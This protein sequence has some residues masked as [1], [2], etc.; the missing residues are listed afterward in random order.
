M[1]N[2]KLYAYLKQIHLLEA[3]IYTMNQAVE[4]LQS[5][6]RML[7]ERPTVQLQIP[8]EPQC[9]EAP[10]K[11]GAGKVAGHIAAAYF[12][13]GLSLIYSG[14]KASKNIK[15][16]S[17]YETDLAAWKLEH[18]AWEKAKARMIAESEACAR[19][20]FE[21]ENAEIQSYNNSISNIILE[22][23]KARRSTASALHSLYDQN[24][25]HEKYRG[26]IPIGMFCEY[27]ETGRRFYLSGKD[28][29]YDL[30]EREL[31]ARS[32]VSE[33]QTINS[34]LRRIQ[35]QM[36]EI[37]GQLSSIQ[38]NQVLTYKAVAEGNRIANEIKNE[39]I[40]LLE[41]SNE[42]LDDARRDIASIKVSSR[43]TAY[44]AEANA[45]STA[46]MERMAEHKFY[47]SEEA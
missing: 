37:S 22:I 3:D 32:I 12:T 39:T 15:N 4:K 10:K 9:P 42:M 18:T 43:M 20:D 17:Q 1:E 27:M 2:E 14:V 38:Y 35:A 7:K 45:R 13:G 47:L 24:I 41:Q 36:G 21:R 44:C 29:M 5:S 26:M 46:A 33:I 11:T 25:V 30:Y 40:N 31:S 19:A 16:R 8:P 34:N 28:E 6:K 23:E